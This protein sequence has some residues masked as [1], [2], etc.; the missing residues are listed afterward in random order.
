VGVDK[1]EC[2]LAWVSL[3]WNSIGR[4][5]AALYSDAGEDPS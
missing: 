5:V 1:N 2:G 3:A 4:R